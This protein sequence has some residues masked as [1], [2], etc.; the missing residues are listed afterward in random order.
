MKVIKKHGLELMPTKGMDR[1]VWLEKRKEGL[2]GSDMGTILGV[3]K[4]FSRLELFYQKCGATKD[5]TKNNPAMHWGNRMEPLVLHDAQYLNLETQ[6]YLPNLEAGNKLRTL[7]EFKYMV[8]NS[9]FPWL[10]A[11]IDGINGINRRKFKAKR[12]AEIKTISRQS[13]EMWETFPIYHYFQVQMYHLVLRP[14]LLEDADDIFYLKDGR[15]LYGYEIEFNFSVAERILEESYNFWQIVLRGREI[16]QNTH[17][18]DKQLS[19]LAEIEPE[20]EHNEAYLDFVSELYKM[21]SNFRRMEGNDEMF[22]YVTHYK[23]IGKQVSELMK[24]RDHYKS[25]IMNELRLN[26]AN[27]ID[28]GKKGRVTFNKKLYVNID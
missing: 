12:I 15:D 28:F 6:E 4:N 18:K 3:N 7:T 16:V 22:G 5:S 9:S 13:A 23:T 8:R 26:E 11:N 20:P 27:I 1:N 21:K 19:Y 17:N 24:D 2:G 10:L 25:I 14:M